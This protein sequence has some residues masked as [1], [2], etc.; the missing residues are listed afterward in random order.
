[1]TADKAG[2][3]LPQNSLGL[4]L[5][6]YDD[7]ELTRLLGIR[8]SDRVLDVGGGAAPF[9]PAEVVVDMYLHDNIHRGGLA[10]KSDTAEFVEASVEALPFAACSFDV[11]I[12]RHVLEH[13]NDP[14]A[15]CRELAR[16]GSRGY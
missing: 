16:V 4:L 2:M 14:A 8:P 12:C 10:A 5:P 15:A 6:T 11:V 1:M 9:L 3:Q 7:A 13:V